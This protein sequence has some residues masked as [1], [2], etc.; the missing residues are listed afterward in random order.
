MRYICVEKCPEMD[1]D[2]FGHCVEHP[3][4]YCHTYFAEHGCCP[5]GNIPVWVPFDRRNDEK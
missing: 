1:H 3:D 4:E 5:V 2:G